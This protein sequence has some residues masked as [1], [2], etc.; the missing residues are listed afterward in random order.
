MLPATPASGSVAQRMM[1]GALALAFASACAAPTLPLPPPATPSVRELAAGRFL[2]VG[3]RGAEPHA[4]V[5]IY[6]RNPAMTLADRVEATEADAEGS[7]RQEIAASPD[8]IVD[9]WQEGES[10]RS[11]PITI[12]LPSR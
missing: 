6:N 3:E 1:R 12:K 2:L 10:T 4:I 11:P 9:I 7:W 8:D 5:V